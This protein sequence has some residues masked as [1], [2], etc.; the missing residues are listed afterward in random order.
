MYEQYDRDRL[1]ATYGLAVELKDA[2]AAL[3]AE[4]EELKKRP[5]A[6]VSVGGEQLAEVV[7][8]AF[9]SR[10]PAIVKAVNDDAAERAKE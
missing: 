6:N 9:D 7:A 4:V 3:T 5:A 1:S 2:V 10:I 8:S